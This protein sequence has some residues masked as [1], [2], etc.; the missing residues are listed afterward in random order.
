[1]TEI[2]KADNKDKAIKELTQKD[3][4]RPS[5]NYLNGD[6]YSDEWPV[7]AEREVYQTTVHFLK[8]L[9]TLMIR[10]TLTYLLRTMF[11]MK[12]KSRLER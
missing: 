6:G 9:L 7:E 8:H 5:E 12:L 4:Y 10:R 2:E 3:I 1:M 11:M